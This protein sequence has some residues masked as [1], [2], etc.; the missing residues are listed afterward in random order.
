[1]PR[2][3]YDTKLSITVTGIAGR[4]TEH[5]SVSA[6]L[7]NM[8]HPGSGQLHFPSLLTGGARAET[9]VVP[10]E[11]ACWGVQTAMILASIIRDAV[12]RAIFEEAPLGIQQFQQAQIDLVS[13]EPPRRR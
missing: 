4:Q 1:M 8:P 7:D 6:L 10:R 2:T 12:W 11:F 9:E 13:R 5:F 3:S